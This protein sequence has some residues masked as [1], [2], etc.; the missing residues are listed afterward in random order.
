[1]S[2]QAHCKIG[3]G[4]HILYTIYGAGIIVLPYE[5]AFHYIPIHCL[6]PMQS[7]R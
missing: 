6:Y 3:Y 2:V 5:S 1:M 4:F 7:Y